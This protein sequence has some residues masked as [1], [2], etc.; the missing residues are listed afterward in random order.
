[1]AIG[2]VYRGDAGPAL[3]ELA[4][5]ATDLIVVGTRRRGTLARIGHGRAGRSGTAS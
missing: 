1:M 4:G 3:V 2:M 5:S